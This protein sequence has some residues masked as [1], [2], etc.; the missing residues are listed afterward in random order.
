VNPVLPPARV[1]L[2]HLFA[3]PGEIDRSPHERRRRLQVVFVRSLPEHQR[4]EPPRARNARPAFTVDEQV[5]REQRRIE[6]RSP[7]R[8]AVDIPS[9]TDS[10]ECR[11]QLVDGGEAFLRVGDR[12]AQ[13]ETRHPGIERAHRP[14]EICETSLVLREQRAQ[15]R[16]RFADGCADDRLPGRLGSLTAGHVHPSAS[17]P[18]GGRGKQEAHSRTSR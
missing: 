15:E 9:L 18:K 10:T 3:Q 1:A 2:E 6:R 14:E 11:E 5:T 4:P 16:L 17:N 7:E 13:G 8:P 12:R